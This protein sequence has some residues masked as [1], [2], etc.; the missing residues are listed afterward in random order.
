[1]NNEKKEKTVYRAAASVWILCIGL[2][3]FLGVKYLLPAILPFIFAWAIA[4]VTR[5]PAD[6]IS[7]SC[8]IRRV[9]IRP[10]LSVLLMLA[11]VGGGVSAL[12]RL[13]TEAWQLFT[14]LGESG[15]LA[16]FVGVVL[17][18]I[19]GMLEDLGIPEELESGLADAVAG[20]FSGLV[21]RLA[22]IVTAVVSGL[23][24]LILFIVI[25]AISSVYFS[26]DLERINSAVLSVLPER[27]RCSV[28]RIRTAVSAVAV[29]YIRSYFILMV[30]TFAV[31]LIGLMLMRIRY[32]LLMAFIISLLDALP[33][34][35]IGIILVPWGIWSLIT[36]EM[37][38]GIGLLIL[39]AVSAI[40][41]QIAEPR[42]VGKSLGIHPLVTILLM[43]VGYTLFGLAGLIFLP[44][45]SALITTVIGKDNTAEVE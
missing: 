35:G 45:A 20:A 25:T 5:R 8:G 38:I 30:I 27:A 12:I 32:A 15:E 11:A 42:I 29:K 16:A 22:G 1:M 28:S 31:I 33:V 10:I 17:D 34:I 21:G 24:R 6:F 36:G 4:F 37:G 14:D 43:Y 2:F 9:F 13:S 44:V 26:I 3:I 23:P 39:Y 18:P 40:V 7:E 19:R 41:R